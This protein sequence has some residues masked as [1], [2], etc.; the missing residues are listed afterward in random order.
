MSPTDH[1]TTGNPQKSSG[2]FSLMRNGQRTFPA[3]CSYRGQHNSQKILFVPS[4]LKRLRTNFHTRTKH[5]VLLLFKSTQPKS[6]TLLH[7]Q[8]IPTYRTT[9]RLTEIVGSPKV[10]VASPFWHG[11]GQA[12]AIFSVWLKLWNSGG[13][14]PPVLPHRRKQPNSYGLTTNPTN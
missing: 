8:S 6:G 4:I 7:Q 14:R 12:A 3:Y 11:Q 1:L 9:R 10:G 13:N 5:V 2:K